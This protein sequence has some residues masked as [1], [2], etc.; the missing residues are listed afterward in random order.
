M[1][2]ILVLLVLLLGLAVPTLAQDGGDVTII[3]GDEEQLRD[4]L[5][6]SL[7]F[8]SAAPNASTT[9]YIGA[10][11]DDLPFE[12]AL[13]DDVRIIGSVVNTALDMGWT[14]IFYNA[15]GTPEEVVASFGQ[16]ETWTEAPNYGP[17]PAGFVQ[18]TT[19][20]MMFCSEDNQTLHVLA[21]EQDG[22]TLVRLNWQQNSDPYACGHEG[23]PPSRDVFSLMPRLETPEGVRL[24][25]GGS[26]GGGGGPAGRQSATSSSV[27]I[28]EMPVEDLAPLYNEQI[29]AQ[30]WEPVVSHAGEGSATSTW[31][32]VDDDGGRWAAVLTLT[33][34][35]LTENEFFAW[36][37]VEEGP[38]DE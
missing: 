28:T 18:Q 25:E 38:P 19:A 35:P 7:G 27:L 14:Q 23:T 37:M 34:N 11:P 17:P 4:F 1:K 36:L 2:R 26:R 32:H 16:T 21:S 13:P 10:L 3:G 5:Q 30:G 29:A 31:A 15:E 24:R 33:A 8:F 12:L 9:I 22:V 20:T 6:V